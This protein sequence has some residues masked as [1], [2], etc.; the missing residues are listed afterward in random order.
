MAIFIER[1]KEEGKAVFRYLSLQLND[2]KLMIMN[3]CLQN[4]KRLD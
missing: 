4:A 3:S 1:S 2:T